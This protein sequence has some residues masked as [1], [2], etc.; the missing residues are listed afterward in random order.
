MATILSLNNHLHFIETDKLRHIE[1]YSRK[2]AKWLTQK[3]ETE[4]VWTKPL[5]VDKTHYLV[6]DGQHRMEAAKLLNLRYVPC[7]L[8][9]Y[10]DVEIWSLRDNYHVD[11]ETVIERALKNDIYPYKTVKHRFPIELPSLAIPL[12]ELIAMQEAPQP[13]GELAL[14]V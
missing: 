4:Q 2:R 1:D 6:M 9:D 13:S 7:M 5:C 8:F 14:C 11:H 12:R 3:I 10:V